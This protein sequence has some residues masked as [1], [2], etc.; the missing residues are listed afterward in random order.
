MRRMLSFALSSALAAVFTSSSFAADLPRRPAPVYKAPA[1]VA[2]YN[3]T[4]FYVGAHA[5]YGWSDFSSTDLVFG[6]PGGAKARGWLGGVQLG[7]NYQIGSIVLG[8]EG[9]YSWADVKFTQSDPLGIGAAGSATLKNDFFATAAGRLGYAFDRFLVY[10]KVGGAWT[11]DKFDLTDGIGGTATGR[12][13]RSGWVGGGGLEYAFLGN[14]SAKLE[15]NYMWF[16]TIT[17]QLTT[18][19]GLVATPANV[20]LETQIIKAGVNYKFF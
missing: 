13:N 9:E 6:D 20:K 8:V 18:G 11:R 3:W 12:F 16:G 5:G 19:G 15:Y 1:A 10:G 17:E 2:F 4:G 7:Y 14:W